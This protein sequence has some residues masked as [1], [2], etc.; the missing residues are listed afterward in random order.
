MAAFTKDFIT[1]GTI[2]EF[3][4]YNTEVL[5]LKNGKYFIKNKCGNICRVDRTD[6]KICTPFIRREKDSFMKVHRLLAC[7]PG[8]GNNLFH[9]SKY[10][11]MYRPEDKIKEWYY[12]DICKNKIIEE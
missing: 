3:R 2:V 7:E 9:C 5:E 11:L 8:Y 1:V 12:K 4:N 10:F 6:I